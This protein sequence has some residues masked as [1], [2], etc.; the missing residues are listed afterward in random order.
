MCLILSTYP[1]ALEPPVRQL[2]TKPRL[3]FRFGIGALAL[4]MTD[5]RV[6][7][8]E[9]R[10]TSFR[11]TFSLS[12]ADANAILRCAARPLR[13]DRGVRAGTTPSRFSRF[14]RR[15]R[16]ALRKPWPDHRWHRH[17]PRGDACAG[18]KFARVAAACQAD[19]RSADDGA[20]RRA[21][22][23]DA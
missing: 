15:A 10:M 21:R 7:P 20:L 5:H 4:L 11:R 13:S 8:N 3:D 19:P 23:G 16:P 9:R 18:G 12:C 1:A 2:N 22:P 17:A 14:E 6:L